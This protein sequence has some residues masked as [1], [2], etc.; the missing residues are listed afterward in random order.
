MLDDVLELAHVPRPGMRPQGAHGTFGECGNRALAIPVRPPV[1]AQEVVGEQ[2]DVLLAVL[3]ARNVDRDDPQAIIQILAERARF[4]RLLGIT[5]RRRDEAHV[6]DGIRRLA[7][8]PPYHAVLDHPQQ[9]RLRRLGHL[10]QLIEEEG[11]AV[12]RLEQTGLVAHGAGER[13]LAVP[14]HLRLEQCLGKRGAVQGHEGLAAAAAVSVDELR[15]QF[16]A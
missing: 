7:T 5:V 15:N 14:E 12:G 3:Q 16:L 10:E 4:D 2:R 13:T 6:D 11:A 8:D 1:I 9:L